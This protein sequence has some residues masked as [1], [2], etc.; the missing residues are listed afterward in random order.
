MAGKMAA[1]LVSGAD[2]PQ[3]SPSLVDVVC[4]T[5]ALLA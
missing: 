1:Q 2:K 4:L 5:L 3:F